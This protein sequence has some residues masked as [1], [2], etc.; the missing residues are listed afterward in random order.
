[1]SEQARRHKHKWNCID[2]LLT[3]VTSTVYLLSVMV[4]LCA[5]NNCWSKP[6]QT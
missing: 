5:P 6:M 2:R 4:L 3:T 1:M